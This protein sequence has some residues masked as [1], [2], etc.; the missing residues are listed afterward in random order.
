ML[1]KF[2]SSQ[3]TDILIFLISTI[4]L[5]IVGSFPAVSFHFMSLLLVDTLF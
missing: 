4:P 5:E 2:T 1:K 3:I